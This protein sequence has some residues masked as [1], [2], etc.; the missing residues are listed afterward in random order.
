MDIVNIF[1][2]RKRKAKL[3][4]DLDLPNLENE[5]YWFLRTMPKKVWNTGRLVKSSK[6]R[7]T[8]DTTDAIGPTMYGRDYS[9]MQ[10]RPMQFGKNG[11]ENVWSGVSNKHD[12]LS[13][14]T[15]G[16]D[17]AK[18]LSLLDQGVTTE[19]LLG[20][21]WD[22]DLSRAVLQG[23]QRATGDIDGYFSA[24]DVVKRGYLAGKE[25][26]LTVRDAINFMQLER[27]V[28][29]P[30]VIEHLVTREEAE[31]RGYVF[32]KRNMPISV[33]ATDRNEALYDVAVLRGN[34]RNIPTYT[35]NDINNKLLRSLDEKSLGDFV[36]KL[37]SV[38]K[39]KVMLT[40]RVDERTI[41][42]TENKLFS[43]IKKTKNVVA[44]KFGLGESAINGGMK[45]YV[46]QKGNMAENAYLVV[47]EMVEESLRP[48]I[49]ETERACILSTD[50]IPENEILFN[51]MRM[52]RSN[53][54]PDNLPSYKQFKAVE[55]IVVR[56]ASS[57]IASQVVKMGDLD[58]DTYTT[59]SELYK[60]DAMR[61]L[62][63]VDM[64]EKNTWMMPLIADYVGMTLP[65]FAKDMNVDIAK[66]AD[67]NNIAG[68]TD[69]AQAVFGKSKFDATSGVLTRKKDEA[70]VDLDV[71]DA[72]VTST[73]KVVNV[74]ELVNRINKQNLANARA[75]LEKSAEKLYDVIG[76][77]D[78]AVIDLGNLESYN[79]DSQEL[80]NKG[81]VTYH[82]V[83]Q[84]LDEYEAMASIYQ[85][86]HKKLLGD[87]DENMPIS[88]PFN[89]VYVQAD[90]DALRMVNADING[91][92]NRLRAANL[93]KSYMDML[94]VGFSEIR[95]GL[96]KY[97]LDNV[98][99]SELFSIIDRLESQGKDV[100]VL[101]QIKAD[102]E[103]AIGSYEKI[104]EW[105]DKRNYTIEQ[106]MDYVG[107]TGKSAEELTVEQMSELWK[108]FL[109]TVEAEENN[110]VFVNEMYEWRDEIASKCDIVT[111]IQDK[112]REVRKNLL[113]NGKLTVEQMQDCESMIQQLSRSVEDFADT[114]DRFEVIKTNVPS[115]IKKSENWQETVLVQEQ[116]T[117]HIMDTLNKEV[118]LCKSEL[119]FVEAL[120]TQEE[121]ALRAVYANNFATYIKYSKNAESMMPELWS[122]A[123][124]TEIFRAI[125]QNGKNVNEDD[126]SN[127]A[128]QWVNMFGDLQTF[129]IEEGKPQEEENKQQNTNKP[130]T[131]K[132]LSELKYKLRAGLISRREYYNAIR[133]K[134]AKA[135]DEKPVNEQETEKPQDEAKDSVVA[136][137]REAVRSADVLKR[138]VERNSKKMEED[139]V[140]REKEQDLVN[141]IEDWQENLAFSASMCAMSDA[142]FQ[143]LRERDLVK[144]KLTSEQLEVCQAKLQS[145]DK[146]IKITASY[147]D[148]FPVLEAAVKET[149]LIDDELW[150]QAT[151]LNDII[152]ERYMDVLNA[153]ADMFRAELDFVQALGT[154]KEDA[155]KK[156]YAD[157]FANYIKIEKSK[158]SIPTN[159]NIIALYLGSDDELNVFRSIYKNA[160][161]VNED[162]L[163]NIAK[164]WV[165]MFGNLQSTQTNSKSQNA[166]RPLTQKELSEL[167]YKLRSGT[168][169]R[170]EYYNAIR[171]SNAKAEP[172]AEEE[173]SVNEQETEKTQE[174][175]KNSVVANIREAVRNAYVLKQLV[176]KN[177]AKVVEESKPQN[178]NRPL[179]QKELSELKYKLRS[180]TITRQEYYNAIRQSKAKVEPKAEEEKSV[181]EQE[182]E[183][184][185]EEAK[186]SVVANIREA[187]RN[188]DA[189]KRLVERKAE[190]TVEQ[191]VVQQIQVV[192]E[193]KQSNAVSAEKKV[194][195][196]EKEKLE[197]GYVLAG[198]K[199]IFS[200]AK[201]NEE[202]KEIFKVLEPAN[203]PDFVNGGR[204]LQKHKKYVSYKNAVQ[205]DAFDN[206]I[207]QRAHKTI[208]KALEKE[209][210]GIVR[211]TAKD[212]ETDNVDLDDV[213]NES[214]EQDVCANIMNHFKVRGKSTAKM[215]TKGVE[216]NPRFV[217]QLNASESLE[218]T[219]EQI[220]LAVIEFCNDNWEVLKDYSASTVYRLYEKSVGSKNLSDSIRGVVV[221][222]M[223][224]TV[225]E[226]SRQF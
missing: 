210:N 53:Q 10:S 93:Y 116:L 154:D 29:D 9:A 152:S 66:Y 225:Y 77:L 127:V 46:S 61:A 90:V 203:L 214:T 148:E 44:K 8:I 15:G 159:P 81:F 114:L 13:H 212:I 202:L 22:N 91:K 25:S 51:I 183:K 160:K 88:L 141:R 75:E 205:N 132:E 181:N 221:K 172:K 224:S 50:E 209:Y 62:S 200:V 222:P 217:A 204:L 30:S 52:T 146:M 32:D 153:R 112:Y 174:D 68:A 39:T 162:E 99:E 156:A 186:N 167:K 109:D 140:L 199:K 64:A 98:E 11:L 69:L 107:Y 197:L 87:I 176:E 134:P 191:A 56:A 147:L 201:Y 84:A 113:A 95:S 2:N 124:E 190:K 131:Q 179:T 128:E 106:W 180:G 223:V 123:G 129:Q 169:T 161:K 54:R 157:K 194:T 38:T 207:L 143:A 97:N 89:K 208:A 178:A 164:Q 187:V 76:D 43:V 45:F 73:P 79:A 71:F 60:V 63:K 1:R 70:K 198:D 121:D 163:S 136:N 101:S 80:V 211:Q 55:D 182:A 120:G 104:S 150:E 122:S 184:T 6:P 126:L 94:N 105:A 103:D 40:N 100:A 65:K 168:I 173:K 216:S 5:K 130:L 185:Q 155:K 142:H 21:E 20:K 189:L 119:D 137:I 48:L 115:N 177:S 42:K 96:A 158:A 74:R 171:Q 86:K 78:K 41:A 24:T 16:A 37:E 102:L 188:A 92:D 220:K 67:N 196:C 36:T 138:I 57:I 47:R 139:K 206:E 18:V 165:S 213:S 58:E 111:E 7:F 23:V 4:S 35:I 149:S 175:A 117:K 110:Q 145:L 125:Y 12:I 170:Q 82:A 118:E 193:S 17:T 3:P 19:R 195:E 83:K 226:E 33:F 28:K 166:N 31:R 14:M 215:K 219:A 26:R 135:E 85:D 108:G 27:M 72:R 34:D 151:L 192:E 49:R 144:G 133:V 59:L 218:Y